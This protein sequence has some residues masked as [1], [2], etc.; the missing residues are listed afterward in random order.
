MSLESFTSWR[1]GADIFLNRVRDTL[2]S[3][4]YTYASAA[5]S[6]DTEPLSDWYDTLSGVTDGFR[7]RPVAGGHLALVRDRIYAPFLE[8][9]GLYLVGSVDTAPRN[10]LCSTNRA[11]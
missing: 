7:A 6:E 5:L 9:D 11:N 1:Q 3:G 8:T 10:L 4:V 2:V